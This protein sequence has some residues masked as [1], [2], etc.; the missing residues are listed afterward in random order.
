MGNYIRF[1]LQNLPFILFVILELISIN[2]AVNYN[3][4]RKN[5]FLSTSNEITG[6]FQSKL[7]NATAY[8]NLKTENTTLSQENAELKKQLINLKLSPIVEKK[9]DSTSIIVRDTIERYQI[10]S[11][12]IISNSFS[13]LHNYITINAGKRQ[14][15]K[16]G[17]GVMSSNGPIGIVVNAATNYSKVISLYNIETSISAKIKH[18]NALGV[19]KWDPYDLR[20]VTMREIPRHVE[21]AKGD[22]VVT[23]GYSFSFP[24]DIPIGVVEDFNVESGEND[25]TVRVRLIENNYQLQNCFIVKDTWGE[26]HQI[27]KNMNPSE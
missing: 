27:L 10:I 14:G 7:G 19:I 16:P 1:I 15:V 13:S 21:L 18:N 6:F 25:F 11:A 12:E 23:S 17:M 8:L 9:I 22:T 26:S 5:L 20:F 4:R 2:L 3:D 24:K